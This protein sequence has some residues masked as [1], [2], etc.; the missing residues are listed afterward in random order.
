MKREERNKNRNKREYLL[1]VL[2]EV[3]KDVLDLCI[4]SLRGIDTGDGVDLSVLVVVLDD[5]VRGLGE[6]AETLLD[7]LDVVVCAT[8]GLTTL[9]QALQHHLLGAL[10]V[11]CELAWNDLWEERRVIEFSCWFVVDI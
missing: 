1:L 11:Q 4:D 2:E 7:G 3:G 10:K 6:D 9:H 5:R 8:A